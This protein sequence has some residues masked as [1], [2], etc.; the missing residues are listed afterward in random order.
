MAAHFL[1][2]AES[3]TI[4]EADVLV[5]GFGIDLGHLETV[6]IVSSFVGEG[7]QVGTVLDGDR[8]L[9]W[10]AV[11]LHMDAQLGLDAFLVVDLLDA[12]EGV[13]GGSLRYRACDDDLLHQLQLESAHR[14]EP[15]DEVI[16]IAVRGGVAQGAEWVERF[17]RFL[18]LVGRVHT[19]RLVDD[20]D[21]PGCLH[22]LDG[23]AAGELVA[24]FIDHVALL[25]SLGAGEVLAE[26]VDVD[27]QDLQVLL[28]AN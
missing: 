20:H 2:L 1:T 10:A 14:I 3:P 7:E 26:G 6:L 17:D 21:G 15:I 18:S 13:V 5:A 11:G 23:L 12:H 16:G 24:L 27:D 19:L 22:E 9:F 4:A 28:V 8:L 25:L